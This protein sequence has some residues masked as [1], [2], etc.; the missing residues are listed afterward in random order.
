MKKPKKV[1]PEN[2]WGHIAVKPENKK[3]FEYLMSFLITREN[4]KV[5]QDELLHDMMEVY[6]KY[7]I[8]SLVIN[9]KKKKKKIILKKVDNSKE[10]KTSIILDDK[11]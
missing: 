1:Q 7:K 11:K 4:P 6:E 2:E 5:T 8:P 9:E 3:R 10:D